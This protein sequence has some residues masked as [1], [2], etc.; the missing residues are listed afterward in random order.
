MANK[1]TDLENQPQQQH[2]SLI[3]DLD[4]LQIL[5]E[6]ELQ[7]V[8]GGGGRYSSNGSH[9]PRCRRSRQSNSG[10]GAGISLS[11]VTG[12]LDVA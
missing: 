4:Q 5:S 6:E 12:G 10:R 2:T 7:G 3:K 9:I 8:V 11:G 1:I